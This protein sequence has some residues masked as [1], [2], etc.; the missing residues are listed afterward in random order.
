MPEDLLALDWPHSFVVIYRDGTSEPLMR[1]TGVTM[2]IPEDDPDGFSG[3]CADIPKKHPHNQSQCG[4][5]IRLVELERIL[6]DA[7]NVLYQAP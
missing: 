7:G 2:I 5:C 3:F 6:D 1:G 4:R